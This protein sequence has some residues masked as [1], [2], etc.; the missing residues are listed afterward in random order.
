[1]DAIETLAR[2]IWG[3]ARGEPHLGQEAVANVVINRV[4][5]PCW[6]GDSVIS[7]CRAPWQFSCWNE[8]D[9]N[10]A[11]LLAVTADDREFAAILRIAREACAGELPDLTNGANSYYAIGAPMPAWARDA[12]LTLVV[13][14]HRFYRVRETLTAT[15]S[16]HAAVTVSDA[17]RLNA[18]ELARLDQETP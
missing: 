17:D 2:T 13:G 5:T 15:R 12:A 1:M 8:D 9:P 10:R 7:V 14:H 6:W 18:A 11:K 3:E 16:V 4:R